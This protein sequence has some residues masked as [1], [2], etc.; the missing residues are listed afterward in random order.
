MDTARVAKEVRHDTREN[1]RA[2][3]PRLR[4]DGWHVFVLPEGIDSKTRFF[5]AVVRTFPLDPP[6][7]RL[8]D[9]WDALYDSL[10][11]G[12]LDV[13]AAK[14]AILWPDA[15][16]LALSEPESHEIATEILGE[17]AE[18]L[19]HGEWTDDG[20]PKEISLLLGTAR[21]PTDGEP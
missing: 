11:A 4:G 8:R 9:V 15:Y 21:D 14:I 5:D 3:E 6:L 1:V 7:A 10:S 2:A 19:R 16:R 20:K 17:L 18:V 13:P 12:L